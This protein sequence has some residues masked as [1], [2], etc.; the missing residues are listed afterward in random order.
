MDYLTRYSMLIYTVM[1][2]EENY[3]YDDARKSTVSY[4]VH[5]CSKRHL[6]NTKREDLAEST[7]VVPAKYSLKVKSEFLITL[8][9]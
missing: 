9:C 8:E 6:H 5:T 1:S 7:G 3:K 4:T 2:A